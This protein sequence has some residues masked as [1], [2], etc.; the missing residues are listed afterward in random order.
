YAEMRPGGYDMDLRGRAT[1][2]NGT[3][4][5]TLFATSPGFARTRL[6]G[7]PDKKLSLAALK[8]FNDWVVGEVPDAHPGRFIPI[9]IIPFF[10]ADASVAE[11][12]IGRAHV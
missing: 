4:A 8:A 1:D 10:D 9:G 3:L 11:I 2:A 7:L 6:A 12:Q 5:A